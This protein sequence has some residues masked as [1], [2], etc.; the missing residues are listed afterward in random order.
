MD[1]ETVLLKKHLLDLANQSY[2][3]NM[4]TFTG[5]LSLHEQ[6][7][8]AEVQKETGSIRVDLYGG[9]EECERVMARFGNP[10]ELGYEEEFP[11]VCIKIE[12]LIEKFADSLTHRDFLGAIMNLGI[13][14]STIGDIFVQGKS[15][16]V[17]CYKKMAEYFLE[18]LDK[19]KHTNVRCKIVEDVAQLPISE[20]TP[21]EVLVSSVRMD[22]VI[23]KVYNISRTGSL[24]LFRTGRV[25]VNGKLMENNA[26]LL[27]EGDMVTARGFGKFS[28]IR[29]ITVTKKDKV[30]ILVGKYE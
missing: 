15:A 18:E 28:Y 14:R 9:N 6:Q 26:Y 30:R 27:K 25:F 21:Q 12:P 23:A 2:Q 24:E 1:K 13:E 10:D 11:I 20:P 3:N 19:V 16:F 4:F 8:L 22:G 29:E 5:F 17:Y 7:L